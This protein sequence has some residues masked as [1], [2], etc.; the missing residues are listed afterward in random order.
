MIW[1]SLK[2]PELKNDTKAQRRLRTKSGTAGRST[3]SE[4]CTATFFG[5][6]F[7]SFSLS[8]FANELSLLLF[9]L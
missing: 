6:C 4:N 2:E 5:M 8:H 7:S 3:F 9:M 1:K